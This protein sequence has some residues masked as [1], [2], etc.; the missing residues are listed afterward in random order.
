M[1]RIPKKLFHIS[2][3]FFNRIQFRRIW[4]KK[5]QC[6]IIISSNFI[7]LFF[8]VKRRIIH[9]N[10]CIL[11]KSRQK[12][13]FKPSLKKLTS[14]CSTILHWCNYLF[15]VFC[16][17]NICT[18]KFS[19]F[20]FAVNLLPSFWISIFT[21]QITINSC[22]INIYNIFF[23][24]I[25]CFLQVFLY[26]S[27]FLLI[28]TQCLF[29]RVIPSLFIAFLTAS[30]LHPDSSAV[31]LKKASGFSSKNNAS[32]SGS[33]FLNPLFNGLFDKSPVSLYF[34]THWLIVFIPAPNISF[35]SL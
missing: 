32:F 34:L 9:D 1:K 19:S 3:Y 8:P 25:R 28:I 26:L 21:V 35:V 4:R 33:I 23:I 11:R 13:S 31:S 14:H 29:F 10:N 15:S 27:F 22:F 20:Y 6:Y 12:N 5:Y 18:F 16:S 7:Q 2:P 17:N 24:D 30:I